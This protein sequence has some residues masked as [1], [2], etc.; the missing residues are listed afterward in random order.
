[1]RSAEDETTIKLN[2]IKKEEKEKKDKEIKETNEKIKQM[3][4]EWTTFC[5]T[6]QLKNWDSAQK[7]WSKLSQDGHQ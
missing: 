4:T 7:L 6:L 5:Q 2:E 3:N 1:L